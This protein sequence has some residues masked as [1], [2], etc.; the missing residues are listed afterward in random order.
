[1]RATIQALSLLLFTLLFAL[2]NYRLPDWLPA[3]IYLRL[4]PLLGLSAIVAGRAWVSRAM[5]GLALLGAT[6]LVGRFFCSYVCPLGAILDFVDPL[7]FRR[8]KRRTLEADGRLRNVKYV[9]LILFVAAAVAGSSLVYLLDPISLLTRTYTFALLPPFVGVVNLVLDV[10]RPFTAALRWMSIATLSFVQ[11]VFYMSLVTFLIFLGIIALGRL[12]PRFWCRYLCP[13]GALLSLVSPLGR[14]RRTVGPECPACGACQDTCPMGAAV[15]E[16]G[17]R[18]VECIQ[19][20]TCVAACPED[21]VRF[22]AS[23]QPLPIGDLSW[24]DLSRR[25]FLYSVAGGVGLGFAVQASPFTPLQNKV[26]L[27]RPP[28]ALP[29]AEFLTTC[30]R[31]GECMKSC[32]TN[33]LQPC[34]WE[35]GLAGLWTPKLDFR[36][37]ACE[38]ECNVCGKV[39]P[40]QAIRSLDL[41]EKTHAKLGTAILKKEV[42]LVWAQ[43]KLCLICDEICPYDAIVFRTIDGYRRPFVVASRCN[44]CGYCEQRCPVEGDSAI[45]VAP[46]GQI[47]LRTGS[48][49]AEAKKL[50]LD[51]KPNPG[52]D[53]FLL[54]SEGLRV[55]SEKH[56]GAAL[57]AKPQAAPSATKKPKGFLPW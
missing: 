44:G 6:A 22:S 9:V 47:R 37:A 24:P 53:Q 26:Q 51:F 14:L 28:G 40:T 29:E 4:D 34:L 25:G 50:Q 41:E 33:T 54:K 18:L 35:G 5:W 49:V 36:F 8:V 32:L 52:D 15:D 19:C 55:E 16:G 30:I 2:A 13:L 42:C 38:Q 21:I 46:I 45:V 7:L 39:C 31:C 3:D 57:Q 11:P 1:M 12:A 48:Y 23:A 56:E 17:T 10:V 20:R 27:I 43:D